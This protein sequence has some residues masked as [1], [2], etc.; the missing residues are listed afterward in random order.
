V[1]Q[2]LNKAEKEALEGYDNVLRERP[3]DRAFN[4]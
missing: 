3:R 1:P 4:R 2:K